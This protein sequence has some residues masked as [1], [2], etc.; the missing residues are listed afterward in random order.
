[1]LYSADDIHHCRVWAH[2]AVLGKVQDVLFDERAWRL[3]YIAVGERPLQRLIPCA[4]FRG[5]DWSQSEID[6]DLVTGEMEP[7][8]F[9][10]GGSGPLLF[11]RGPDY[12]AGGWASAL[13]PATGLADD[14]TTR[15]RSAQELINYRAEALDGWSGHVEDLFFDSEDWTVRNIA[16]R[17]PGGWKKSRVVVRPAQVARIDSSREA[18]HLALSKR[19]LRACPELEV[20]ETVR[21]ALKLVVIARD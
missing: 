15:C 6:I 18:L 12:G 5:V 3:R 19:A 21:P 7:G 4:S 11:Q 2:D 13:R 14:P 8:L 20:I 17:L 10:L 16:L 9:S 1:M